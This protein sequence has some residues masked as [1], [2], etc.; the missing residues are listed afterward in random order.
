MLS[1]KEK[2]IEK[3]EARLFTNRKDDL[4][5]LSHEEQQA[6]IRT[7]IIKHI[8]NLTM[9]EFKQLNREIKLERAK[10]N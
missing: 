7:L 1:T 10:E 2:K 5:Q 6:R 9:L 8:A 4:N 3:L